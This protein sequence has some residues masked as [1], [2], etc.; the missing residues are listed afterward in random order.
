[1]KRIFGCVCVLLIGVSNLESNCKIFLTTKLKI[2]IV[3]FVYKK[4]WHGYDAGKTLQENFSVFSVIHM[5]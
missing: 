5:C 1:M 4:R 3:S 2:M